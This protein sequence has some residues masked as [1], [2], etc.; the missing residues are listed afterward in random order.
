MNFNFC[1]FK[2]LQC[3][4]CGYSKTHLIETVLLSTQNRHMLKYMGK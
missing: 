4:C 2:G 3:I 1:V